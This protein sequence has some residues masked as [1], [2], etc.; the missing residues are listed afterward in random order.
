MK[1]RKEHDDFI[2]HADVVFFL[3]C[4]II[5]ISIDSIVMLID[6]IVMLYAD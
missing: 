1:Y 3:A 6:S 2:I 5:V 4:M